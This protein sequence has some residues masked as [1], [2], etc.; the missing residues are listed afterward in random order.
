MHELLRLTILG[1]AAGTK[2]DRCRTS[3][4]QLK[5]EPIACFLVKARPRKVIQSIGI[6]QRY[7]VCFGVHARHED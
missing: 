4:A 6:L 3:T 2:R 5:A 1:Y 7:V